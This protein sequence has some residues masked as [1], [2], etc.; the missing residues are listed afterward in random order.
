HS[1]YVRPVAN[2]V[3]RFGPVQRSDHDNN[4]L[5][6]PV[7]WGTRR[8]GPDL[9]HE[10]G[11]RSNDWQIAHL[12]DPASTTPGSITPRYP[13]LFREGFSV[14]RRIDP[15]VAARAGLPEAHSYP[16]P[17]VWDTAEEA[18]AERQRLVAALPPARA[19]EAGRLFV[20]PARGP[21][22]RALSL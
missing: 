2:E 18:E 19:A 22:P 4:A 20:E 11:L 21:G 10:G 14:R 9:T 7:L 17:G 1:Q 13:W 16:L 12:W 5:Q 3:Q 8:V 15:D 6:R